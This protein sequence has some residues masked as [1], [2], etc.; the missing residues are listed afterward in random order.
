MY[1]LQAENVLQKKVEK[2]KVL[3]QQNVKRV[4]TLIKRVSKISN[5]SHSPTTTNTK[6]STSPPDDFSKEEHD[7][8]FSKK[9]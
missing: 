1:N 9:V 5:A 4:K 2:K 7:N 6:L 3:F 8:N